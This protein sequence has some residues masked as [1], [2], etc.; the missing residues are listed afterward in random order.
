MIISSLNQSIDCGGWVGLVR[1]KAKLNNGQYNGHSVGSAG[2]RTPLGP[3]ITHEEF[4]LLYSILCITM[5][6]HAVL[7]YHA[8]S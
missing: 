1:N 2:I 7:Q 6:K 4:R 5:Q 3:I 8:A